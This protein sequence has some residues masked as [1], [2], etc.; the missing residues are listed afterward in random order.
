MTQEQQARQDN[1]SVNH[2]LE[3]GQ[4]GFLQFQMGPRNEVGVNGLFIA[5]DVLPALRD[6]LKAVNKVLPSRE[7][8]LAITKLEE[9]IMWLIERR[10]NREQQGVL[11]TYK[12]H[13]T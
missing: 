2:R 12:P 13:Q 4:Y 1:E 10:N 8:S 7:T 9:C 6:H 3:F 11:G 5:E